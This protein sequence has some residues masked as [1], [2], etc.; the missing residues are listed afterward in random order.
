MQDWCEN[1]MTIKKVW[2]HFVFL[3][4]Q[5]QTLSSHLLAQDGGL[6]FHSH[7]HIQARKKEEQGR[8]AYALPLNTLLGNYTLYCC[9]LNVSSKIPAVT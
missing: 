1:S 5:R 3:H 9:G 4:H 8:G 2:T 6:G 7:V